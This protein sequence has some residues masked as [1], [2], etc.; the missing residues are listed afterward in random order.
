[1]SGA[2]IQFEGWHVG[3]QITA[4]V[5]IFLAFFYFS[6]RAFM[7]KK[8]KEDRLASMPLEDQHPESEKKPSPQE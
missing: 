4:F 5:I 8:D 7:M 2:E 6:I 3:V 1:M